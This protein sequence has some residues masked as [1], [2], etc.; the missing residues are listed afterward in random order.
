M[1]NNQ[2]SQHT[3]IPAVSQSNSVDTFCYQYKQADAT[4]EAANMENFNKF[5]L[6]TYQP[7]DDILSRMDK[8]RALSRLQRKNSPNARRGQY[9]FCF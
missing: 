2:F 8:L 6:V 7:V 4:R 5:A 1:T 9:S 3:V